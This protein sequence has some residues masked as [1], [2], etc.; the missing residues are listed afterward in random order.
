MHNADSDEKYFVRFRIQIKKKKS[1]ILI[2]R[3]PISWLK[4][5]PCYYND[6]K[7]VI[8]FPLRKNFE[9]WMCFLKSAVNHCHR[10]MYRNQRFVCETGKYYF[11]SRQSTIRFEI[12]ISVRTF[13]F[14]TAFLKFNFR[15]H[16]FN[17][18]IHNITSNRRVS[19]VR[20][21]NKISIIFIKYFNNLYSDKIIWFR[22]NLRVAIT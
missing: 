2:F 4:V 22:K 13:T 11:F 21:V 8:F 5:K 3:T 17:N 6:Q 18:R 16:S 12:G 20:I 10:I 9:S 1:L 15:N 14:T 19:M 7:T